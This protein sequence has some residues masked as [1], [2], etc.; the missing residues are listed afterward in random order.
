MVEK[1]FSGALRWSINE[2]TGRSVWLVDL[3]MGIEASHG[4]K[5]PRGRRGVE[6]ALRRGEKYLVYEAILVGGNKRNI[7]RVTYLKS[8]ASK[9]EAEKDFIKR[10]TAIGKP[11]TADSMKKIKRE[12]SIAGN[13]LGEINL[14]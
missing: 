6:E 3:E 8:Y 12:I 2:R 10:S 9:I 4:L 14:E 13:D 5:L 7:D 11:K 1:P